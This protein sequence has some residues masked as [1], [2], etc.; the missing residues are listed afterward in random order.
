MN[1]EGLK[2]RFDIDKYVEKINKLK[3]ETK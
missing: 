1:A 2:R 3:E